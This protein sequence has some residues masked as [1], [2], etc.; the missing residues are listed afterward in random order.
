MLPFRSEIRNS[1]RE[2]TIKIYIKDLAKLT[3]VKSILEKLDSIALLEIQKSL[4]RNRVNKNITVFRNKGV[5]INQ[6]K[7]TIDNALYH[8]FV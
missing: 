2:Q 7:N 8:Y 4:S 6:L 5:D 3:A 1:P